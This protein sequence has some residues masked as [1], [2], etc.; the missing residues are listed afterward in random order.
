M[1]VASVRPLA[2]T[3]KSKAGLTVLSDLSAK[4][5]SRTRLF[6]KGYTDIKGKWHPRVIKNADLGERIGETAFKFEDGP[7]KFYF[8]FTIKVYQWDRN[9][10]RW[11]ALAK[12]KTAFNSYLRAN[13]KVVFPKPS[14]FFKIVK[15]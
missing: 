8:K 14:K 4:I 7:I 10:N 3:V 6:R 15:E 1:S 11:K 12:A 2:E 5:A 13:I 9:E